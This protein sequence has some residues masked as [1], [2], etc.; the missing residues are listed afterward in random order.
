MKKETNLNLGISEPDKVEAYLHK[1]QYPMID[2]VQ[3]IR[4]IILRADKHIG[5]GIY[6]NVPTFFYTGA[7]EPFDPRQYK[8]YLVGF[9]F[10]KK[11]R[12]RL[13]FLHGA[14]AKDKSGLLE[15]NYADGRRLVQ[16][17]GL[18]DVKDKEKAFIAIIKQLVK[19]M[20]KKQ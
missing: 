17:T 19:G 15:G 20:N 13:I 6:W 2:A 18:E 5:E 14:D 11:D 8:R 16:F 7:M 10:Y 9:N 3:Y 12:L 4:K 1:L